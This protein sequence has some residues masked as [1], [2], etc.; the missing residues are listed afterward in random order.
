MQFMIECIKELSSGK[1]HPIR[2]DIE[3]L[4]AFLRSYEAL[5]SHKVVLDTLWRERSTVYLPN[6]YIKLAKPCT[7]ACTIFSLPNY[8]RNW[9]VWNKRFEFKQAIRVLKTRGPPMA[10]ETRIAWKS[11]L[12]TKII[13]RRTLLV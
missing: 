13:Y 7:Q 1:K 6:F 10:L 12:L 5:D 2:K 9:L 3:L 11:A 8:R 4:A